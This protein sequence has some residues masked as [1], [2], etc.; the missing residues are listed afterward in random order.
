M[1]QEEHVKIVG[2]MAISK[3]PYWEMC[4]EKMAG[5]V[6]ELHL[7]FDVRD[8]D[9]SILN[10]L[11]SPGFMQ[12]KIKQVI[13]SKK[14]WNCWNWREELIR[15][16]D[17]VKPGIVISLDQDEAF[18]PGI[19]SELQAFATSQ[20]RAMMFSYRDPMPTIDNVNVPLYPSKPHMKAFKWQPGLTYVPYHSFAKIHPLHDPDLHFHASTKILHY[21]CYTPELRDA[22]RQ[23]LD[24]RKVKKKTT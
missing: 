8:G 21:C 5:I 6:D 19:E 18:E 4:L 3:F 2:Q 10:R 14:A 12:G 23:Q 11:R 7:R 22:K 15:S 1:K 9:P 13:E 16:L 17:D 24:D 20:S